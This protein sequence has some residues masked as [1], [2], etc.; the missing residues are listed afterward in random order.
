[1]LL[2][3]CHQVI[4]DEQVFDECTWYLG[5]IET[6]PGPALVFKAFS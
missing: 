2:N 4:V 3:D 1:M 5:A 6:Y